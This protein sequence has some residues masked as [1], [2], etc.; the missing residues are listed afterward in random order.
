MLTAVHHERLGSDAL[1]YSNMTGYSFLHYI[2]RNKSYSFRTFVS[3]VLGTK[4]LKHIPNP[5][6]T[7]K[8]VLQGT[9]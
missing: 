1:Q 8:G 7:E 4:F 2:Y 3:E 6:R 9:V 5:N